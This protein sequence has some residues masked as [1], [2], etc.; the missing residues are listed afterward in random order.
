MNSI[1]ASEL[2]QALGASLEG[3]GSRVLTGLAALNEA[4][5]SDVS[6]L[7]NDKY[8]PQLDT[9]EA[10]CVVVAADEAVGREDLTLLRVENPSRAFSAVIERF[11]PEPP[12]P[13]PGIHPTAVIEAGAE[14]A[15]DARIGAY[16]VIA[17]GA[18]IEEGV[19]LHPGCQVGVNSRVGRDSE[20]FGRVVLYHEVQVG[21]RCIVHA[22]TVL[23]ADGFGFEPTATGWDKIPQCGTV[24][25]EDDVEIGAN[26]TVDRGRFGATRIGRGAKI[27]N[28]CHV[29]HN[30]QIGEASLL[31]AQVGVA[32]SSKLGKRVIL[33]GKAGVSGHV[34]LA[35][36]VRVGGLSA[37]FKDIDEPGD[38]FGIPAKTSKEFFQHY[39]RT[40]KVKGLL[41]DVK[42]LAKRV[43]ELE[44]R[45]GGS[46]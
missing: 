25:V 19:T 24:V 40:T 44:E 32:G 7:A 26:C 6:F 17:A 16:C 27:D 29:A 31:V 39:H 43:Q 33:A 12:R 35:D 22:G 4:G 36:G 38:Y 14:I 8:K 23:G 11:R 15:R 34:T 45:A 10:G 9:T 46:A 41:K 2:A 42:A 3:D 21:E 13:A 20:L 28:L 18:R 5:P 37:V 1:T 30:V